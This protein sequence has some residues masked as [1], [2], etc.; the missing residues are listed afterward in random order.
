[1]TAVHLV[2]G[3]FL[4]AHGLVHGIYAGQARRL[5][6]VA[7]GATWPDGSWALSR[8]LGDPVVRACVAGA[9]AAV[10]VAF[11]VAGVALVLRA[12][13]WGPVA[14]AAAVVSAGVLLLAWDGR[15]RDLAL[16]GAYALALDAAIVVLALLFRWAPV[17]G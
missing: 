1:M 16:Q 4:V 17:D 10:A 12:P 13:W 9:F 11:A 5:F 3:A 2:A 14:A 7:P 15:P 6:E 8:L